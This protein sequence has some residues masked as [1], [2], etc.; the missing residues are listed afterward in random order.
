L[1]KNG[2]I[3]YHNIVPYVDATHFIQFGTVYQN[4][5]QRRDY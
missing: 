1:I 2:Q 5:N 4:K 3:N